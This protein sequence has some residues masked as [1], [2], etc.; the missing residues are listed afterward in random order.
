MRAGAQTVGQETAGFVA[1]DGAT[2][3]ARREAVAGMDLDRRP[4]GADAELDG[5]LRRP[6][7]ARP[8]PFG[9]GL[10]LPHGRDPGVDAGQPHGV[11]HPQGVQALQVGR[12]VIEHIFDSM[13][14]IS[15]RASRVRFFVR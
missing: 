14:A 6:R 13:P 9:L 7:P 10:P 12:Q 8:A 4:A 11:P 2:A 5:P 3:L 1:A 15:A